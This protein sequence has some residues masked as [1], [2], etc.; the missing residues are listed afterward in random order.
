MKTTP[1]MLRFIAS[2]PT[3]SQYRPA[4]ESSPSIMV[5]P[6]EQRMTCE[7]QVSALWT[8]RQSNKRDVQVWELLSW[9]GSGGRARAETQRSR[10]PRRCGAGNAAGSGHLDG[11][12]SVHAG[13]GGS[14]DE[15]R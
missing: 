9:R 6:C 15:E 14:D 4:V 7:G 5:E 13:K 2:R 1:S 12:G 8:L 10:G 11:T 3:S